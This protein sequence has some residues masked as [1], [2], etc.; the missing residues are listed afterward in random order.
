M[1]GPEAVEELLQR[2][3]ERME[4]LSADLDALSHPQLED[5]RAAFERH[6]LPMPDDLEERLG[7]YSQD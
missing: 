3:L 7:K 1:A 2:E 4:I 5:L 6:G